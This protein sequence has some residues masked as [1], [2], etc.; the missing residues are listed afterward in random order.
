MGIIFNKDGTVTHTPEVF[1]LQEDLAEK[2][3]SHKSHHRSG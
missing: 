2:V 1:N 3:E